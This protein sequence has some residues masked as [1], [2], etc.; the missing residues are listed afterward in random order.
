MLV[1]NANSCEK[2]YILQVGSEFSS[3]FMIGYL[4]GFTLSIAQEIQCGT[5]I[6]GAKNYQDFLT[7]VLLGKAD[8][9]L[10]PS[11]FGQ[12]LTKLGFIPVLYRK[13]T[14]QLV[15]ITMAGS[16]LKGQSKTPI[17]VYVPSEFSM[18]YFSL[19]DWLIKNNLNNKEFVFASTYPSIIM[20]TIK[21]PLMIAS[22]P[23]EVLTRIPKNIQTKL[24]VYE[25][26]VNVGAYIMVKQGTSEKLINAIK[27]SIGHLN[28]DQWSDKI[29]IVQSKYN[30]R[31]EAKLEQFKAENQL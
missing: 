30:Q 25:S 1:F 24:Q 3:N 11:N 26:G 7:T 5:R 4:G 27:A 18:D 17:Q 22:V 23:D 13:P 16:T 8:I 10:V 12:A 29:E 6:K 2:P 20:K 21:T 9:F 31:F 14:S 15:F 19:N 28:S